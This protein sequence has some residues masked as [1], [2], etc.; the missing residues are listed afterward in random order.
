MKF[1][2]TCVKCGAHISKDMAYNIREGICPNC[3]P[4]LEISDALGVL[5]FC[6]IS[7]TL[8]PKLNKLQ[9]LAIIDQYFKGILD[10]KTLPEIFIEEEESDLI[11]LSSPN[12]VISNL[13]DESDEDIQDT[14]KIIQE[15]LSSP[16]NI[17]HT[18]RS[19]VKLTAAEL[20]ELANAPDETVAPITSINTNFGKR[21]RESAKEGIQFRSKDELTLHKIGR[22]TVIPSDEDSFVL[23]EA[24]IPA[25]EQSNVQFK[26][27]EVIPDVEFNRSV[28]LPVDTG[29]KIIV[30]HTSNVRDILGRK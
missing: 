14:P 22:G 15:D 12:K 25:A 3:G 11:N 26:Y 19:H 8:T 1:Y 18:H 20:A 16:Q 23:P 7:Q 28:K 5:E 27:D 29:N 24:N 2:I 10:L 4:G 9:I 6:E 13:E 17:P 30:P 21:D